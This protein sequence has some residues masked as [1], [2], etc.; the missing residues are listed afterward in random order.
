MSVMPL[1]QNC[2]LL[3]KP[4]AKMAGWAGSAPQVVSVGRVDVWQEQ[5]CL[6]KN[7]AVLKLE[8]YCN[9]MCNPCIAMHW[10]SFGLCFMIN[11]VFLLKQIWL[12]IHNKLSWVVYTKQVRAPWWE[13]CTE[14]CSV[15][16]S[17]QRAEWKNEEFLSEFK[18]L[19]G[20]Q[21]ITPL[22]SDY[23]TI[24]QNQRLMACCSC[25]SSIA[26]LFI[27]QCPTVQ[28]SWARNSLVWVLF[29]NLKWFQGHLRKTKCGMQN[30][31][32]YSLPS[33]ARHFLRVLFV[34]FCGGVFVVV[35]FRFCVSW[36][37][38]ILYL[39]C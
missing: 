20:M 26:V 8:V 38:Q 36:P 16:K 23:Y 22:T 14:A 30:L 32:V 17:V 6:I 27:S 39:F 4:I 10:I 18:N 3:G 5:A 24:I 29:F 13:H 21:L 12:C 25:I 11:S 15:L 34:C 2:D 35:V 31:D 28:C 1:V 37:Y 19:S 33:S 9:K 7:P